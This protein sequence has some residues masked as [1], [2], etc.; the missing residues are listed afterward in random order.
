[1]KVAH[2]IS[3]PAS[4]GIEVF[5]KDLVL[6]FAKSGVE[7]VIIFLSSAKDI[8]TDSVFESKYLKELDDN[9]IDYFFLG[10][11]CRKNIIKGGY[12]LRNIVK[13][14][15][16][17]LVHS[18]MPYGVFFSIFKVVPIVYTHH[19]VEA[20]LSKFTYAL[21]NLYINQYV[22]ISDVCA[23]S[24]KKAT[25]KNVITIRNSVTLSKFEGL[26]RVRENK[27]EMVI[28]MAGRI[29]KQKDY[30]LMVQAVSE[31]PTDVLKHI[32]IKIAGEG[33]AVYK[34]KITAL[35][36]KT[37]LKN[38]IKFLGTHSNIPE[39]MYQSDIFLMT[40]KLEGLP[41][42]LIESIISGL[43]SIVTNVGG[44]AEVVNEAKCGAVV[45]P[46]NSAEISKAITKFVENKSLI[47]ELSTN[48]L[49]HAKE[50]DV[51]LN[52]QKHVELYSSLIK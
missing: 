18:H 4:G 48:A 39:L 8:G 21:M 29:I 25:K 45:E 24:L 12:R 5:V 23:E 17:E 34:S 38:K 51:E 6:S 44:C 11:E 1:L 16:I 50:F 28:M 47:S 3:A 7:A 15:N 37:G 41:I 30:L 9:D 20:R 10:N 42:A 43:P 31:L 22:G 33:E 19:S 52:N 14:N 46:N 40:S 13:E 49:S 2:F 35:I 36:E 26:T 32:T 27:S